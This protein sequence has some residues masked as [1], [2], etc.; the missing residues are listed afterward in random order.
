MIIERR[1]SQIDFDVYEYLQSKYQ[2]LKFNLNQMA[3]EPGRNMFI[4]ETYHP[5]NKIT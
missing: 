3:M 5:F 1:N 2:I 4:Q